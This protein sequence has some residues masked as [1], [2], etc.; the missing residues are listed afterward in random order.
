MINQSLTHNQITDL[1]RVHLWKRRQLKLGNKL[2]DENRPTIPSILVTEKPEET[3]IPCREMDKMIFWN[4]NL[5]K[6]AAKW[7]Q[8]VIDDP[9]IDLFLI[10]SEF[11]KKAK[12]DMCDSDLFESWFST[13]QVDYGKLI[14]IAS[15]GILS[16]NCD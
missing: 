5:A 12:M 1:S 15:I 9:K 8:M 11:F 16:L 6:K 10:Q 4:G 3:E 14:A 7:K 13:A 2:E